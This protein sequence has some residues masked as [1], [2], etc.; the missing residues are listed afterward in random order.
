MEQEYEYVFVVEGASV[1]DG[2]DVSVVLGEFDGL[3]A[4]HR[5]GQLLAVSGGGSDAVD[6][7]RK[8]V[9]RLRR[10]LPH[11]RVLRLDPD[12]VGVP[13]IAERTGRSRGVV[14][15]WAEGDRCD[16]GPFPAPEGTAGRSPVWRWGEV[17]AWLAALGEG[18]AAGVPLRE[19]AL[20]VDVMLRRWQRAREG[21]RAA[22]RS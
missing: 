1:T 6:A 9:A 19:E 10:S 12:L 2:P 17:N 8:L 4:T 18:D 3:L 7:A 11:L 20:D 14:R 22:S 16:A 21:A 15:E 5:D 13:D